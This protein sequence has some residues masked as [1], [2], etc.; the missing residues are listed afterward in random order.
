MRTSSMSSSQRS[1]AGSYNG[2]VGAGLVYV[3]VG[4]EGLLLKAVSCTAP[5][6]L[7]S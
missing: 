4:G 7:P 6:A 2:M 3:G 5:R 1:A